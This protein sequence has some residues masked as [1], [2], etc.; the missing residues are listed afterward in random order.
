RKREK[1]LIENQIQINKELE[2]KLKLKSKIKVAFFV[3]SSSIWKLDKVFEYMMENDKFEP[4][5]IICP[6][7]NLGEQKMFEEFSLT[8]N[9]FKSKKYEYKITYDSKSDRWLDI[10]QEIKPDMIFY[11]NPHEGTT[12]NEY[13]IKNYSEILSCYVPYFLDVAK[14]YDIQYNSIFHNLVWKIFTETSMHKEIANKYARVKDVNRV[15]IGA[16]GLDIY[17][18]KKY[19]PKNI[20]KKDCRKKIIWAPHQ[21]LSDNP[22]LKL[23]TFE[24]YCEKILEISKKYQSEIQLAFKPHPMLKVNLEKKWGKEKVDNYYNSWINGENTFLVN[25]AYEDLFLTSDALIHDCASFTLEYLYLNKPV[26]YLN[27]DLNREEVFN[28]IGYKAYNVH[29]QAINEFE[30]EN[31]IKENVLKENDYMHTKRQDFVFNYLKKYSLNSSK[32]IIDYLEEYL[33]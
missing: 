9:F 3:V 27:D 2:Q 11:T 10:K 12:K 31:F 14:L 6:W 24:T 19:N 33:K 32:E 18:D 30:I 4:I 16:P 1:K 23:S 21:M 28:E 5:I 13:F 17:H 20:W 22:L 29:Y 25:G 8:E 15:V 26:L 7:I